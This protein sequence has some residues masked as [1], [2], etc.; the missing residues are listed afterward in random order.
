MLHDASTDY[1][2]SEELKEI[3]SLDDPALIDFLGLRYFEG[4]YVVP[5]PPGSGVQM[6]YH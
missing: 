4:Y 3:R 2:T 6:V 1:T 5:E